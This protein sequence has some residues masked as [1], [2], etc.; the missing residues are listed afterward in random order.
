MV[1]ILCSICNVASLVRSVI[2]I[3]T[4]AGDEQLSVLASAV[5]NMAVSTGTSFCFP[6]MVRGYHVISEYMNSRN[7]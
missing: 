6:L 2:S 3:S 1:I 5:V 4:S 7:R